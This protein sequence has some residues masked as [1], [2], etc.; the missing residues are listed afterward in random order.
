[1]L[2]SECDALGCRIEYRPASDP[3]PVLA[4]AL[5]IQLVLI[6]LLN[7]AIHSVSRCGTTDSVI[8]I[9]AELLNDQMIQVSVTDEGTGIPPD[10][11]EYIFDSLYSD[12]REGMG[13]GLAVCQDIINLH[14]GRIWHDRILPGALSFDLH[15]RR[16]NHE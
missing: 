16:T 1:M 2:Q 14:G 3:S 11:L 15:S 12:K 9:D 7:N 6:N 4:A 5:E 8:S 10:Q 13:M